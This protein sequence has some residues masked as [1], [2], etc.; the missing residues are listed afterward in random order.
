MINHSLKTRFE[1]ALGMGVVKQ[2]G[3]LKREDQ[4]RIFFAALSSIE[5]MSQ[6]E[7]F[8]D[9]LAKFLHDIHPKNR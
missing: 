4:E 8:R 6:R 9:E 5:D 7:L 2:W 3:V 1:Q